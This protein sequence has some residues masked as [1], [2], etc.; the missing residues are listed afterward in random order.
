MGKKRELF[1]AA[2]S[3]DLPRLL[4]ILSVI[5][6]KLS[7]GDLLSCID[8]GGNTPLHFAALN[9]FCDDGK[10]LINYGFSACTSNYEGYTPM[11]LA[12]I[13]GNA[14]FVS[15][16]CGFDNCCPSLDMQ[17]RHGNTALHLAIASNKYSACEALLQNGCNIY[18]RNLI[19]ETPL[20]GAV[21]KKNIEMV[22]LI[23]RHCPAD[24]SKL[25]DSASTPLHIAVRKGSQ[26]MLKILLNAGFSIDTKTVNG[27]CLHEAI[28]EKNL[29]IVGFLINKGADL[30]IKNSSNQTVLELIEKLPK[31]EHLRMRSLIIAS[32]V[33][34][35]N[36]NLK[37]GKKL[38]FVS[39]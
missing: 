20:D 12:S 32:Q 22:K 30:T 15:L 6:K 38:N 17:D 28:Q 11:H 1:D 37:P 24:F 2:R 33:R 16:L 36:K 23:L 14:E 34:K 21:G 18:L 31:E 13:V 26:A 25:T 4:R 35:Q 10:A 27:S 39:S 9:N 7:N 3:H 8:D 29:E 5:S 19:H